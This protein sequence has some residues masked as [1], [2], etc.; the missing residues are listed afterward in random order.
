[1][2]QVRISQPAPNLETGH[3]IAVVRFFPRQHSR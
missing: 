3:I 1:M 2:S